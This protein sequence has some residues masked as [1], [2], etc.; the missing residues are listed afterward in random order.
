MTARLNTD[1][2]PSS[3]LCAAPGKHDNKLHPDCCCCRRKKQKQ[4]CVADGLYGSPDDALL[5]IEAVSKIETQYLPPADLCFDDETSLTKALE[6]YV[7]VESPIAEAE[8]IRLRYRRGWPAEEWCFKEGVEWRPLFERY[9]LI[10]GATVEVRN[11]LEIFCE[12]SLPVVFSA[13]GPNFYTFP[14][15][16]RSA[17]F[18]LRLLWRPRHLCP[19]RRLFRR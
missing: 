2:K 9:G 17:E 18:I 6:A 4:R 8:R 11:S 15:T 12:T 7:D 14:T 10:A 3:S 1:I 13:F 19:P 16:N 5:A